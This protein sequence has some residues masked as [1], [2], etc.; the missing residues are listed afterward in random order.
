MFY[1]DKGLSKFVKAPGCIS[2][3]NSIAPLPNDHH[4]SMLMIDILLSL[5]NTISNTP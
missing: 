2:K 3:I 1:F 5:T 4:E